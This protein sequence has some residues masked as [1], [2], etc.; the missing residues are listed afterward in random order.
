MRREELDGGPW[1]SERSVHERQN[2]I[3]IVGLGF[4][5]SNGV[6]VEVISRGLSEAVVEG[7]SSSND[8]IRL[9]LLALGSLLLW[10]RAILLLQH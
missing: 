3:W 1:L 8:R 10:F 9:A 6:Q 5:I 7:S 4:V 2:M